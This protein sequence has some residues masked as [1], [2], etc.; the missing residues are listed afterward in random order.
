MWALAHFVRAWREDG[1]AI[2]TGKNSAKVLMSHWRLSRSCRNPGGHR[3]KRSAPPLADSFP[4]TATG[5]LWKG[6]VVGTQPG[7]TVSLVEAQRRQAAAMAARK[8]QSPIN[9]LGKGSG[10]CGPSHPP[11]LFQLVGAGKGKAEPYLWERSRSDLGSE[12]LLA[13]GGRVGSRLRLGHDSRGAPH[14]HPQVSGCRVIEA[15]RLALWEGTGAERLTPWH[16]GGAGTWRKAP[17]QTSRHPDLK[18]EDCEG[19][20]AL[21]VPFTEV[22]VPAQLLPRQTQLSRERPGRTSSAPHS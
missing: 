12:R 10:P 14:P 7:E 2:Q 19:G 15:K 20:G 13:T 9:L 21:R 1:A 11:L 22:P 18:L 17:Q 4:W 3:C 5:H 8:A 16:T 6:L